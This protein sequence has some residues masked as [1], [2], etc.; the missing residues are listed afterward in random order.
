MSLELTKECTLHRLKP[1][2][3]VALHRIASHHTQKRLF[4]FFCIMNTIAFYLWMCVC[5]FHQQTIQSLEKNTLAYTHEI[6]FTLDK[7]G[8]FVCTHNINT[9]HISF[10]GFMHVCASD[11]W[12]HF[13]FYLNARVCLC[14][15][16]CPSYSGKRI[17]LMEWSLCKSNRRTCTSAFF[18]ELRVLNPL[19][20]FKRK[21]YQFWYII[22]TFSGTKNQ[23]FHPNNNA[24]E[25]RKTNQANA[26]C[27]MTLMWYEFSWI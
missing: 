1:S 2:D 11:L 8:T 4:I 10:M 18:H 15:V 25:K 24:I 7:S 20:A 26:Y 12:F 23:Q 13:G 6:L 14:T 22:C 9:I 19:K 16:Q 5:F 21:L 3:I 17:I 27:Q